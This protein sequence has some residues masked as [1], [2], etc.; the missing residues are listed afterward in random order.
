MYTGSR[1]KKIFA[2]NF[3]KN[4]LKKRKRPINTIK[5]FLEKR[6]NQFSRKHPMFLVRG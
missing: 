5:G 3:Q 6:A 4:L 2:E 1:G